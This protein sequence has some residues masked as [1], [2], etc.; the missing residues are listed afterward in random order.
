LYPPPSPIAPTNAIRRPTPIIPAKTIP[1]MEPGLDSNP[2][3]EGDR[4][5]KYTIAAI[6]MAPIKIDDQF[7]FISIR[8]FDYLLVKIA[9]NARTIKMI[10]TISPMRP[11]EARSSNPSAVEGRR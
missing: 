1:I 9:K 4:F 6:P 8:D 5:K 7:V 10:K 11:P 2:S 3:R